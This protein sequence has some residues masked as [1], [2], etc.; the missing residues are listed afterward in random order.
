MRCV[1]VYVCAYVKFS[2]KRCYCFHCIFRERHTRAVS[3]DKLFNWQLCTHFLLEKSN[4]VISV[5]DGSFLFQR[6]FHFKKH[7]VQEL[8]SGQKKPKEGAVSMQS[9]FANLQSSTTK[10]RVRGDALEC[11]PSRMSACCNS[12]ALQI[13]VPISPAQL[14][15]LLRYSA[16]EIALFYP[17]F[18]K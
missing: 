11:T 13:L 7:I 4:L 5:F 12:I 8:N 17:G 6:I 2:S 18:Y 3:W 1:C 15:E 14:P 16:S 9:L 10:C